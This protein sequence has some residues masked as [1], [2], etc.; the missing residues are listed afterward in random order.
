MNKYFIIEKDNE[1]IENIKN[2]FEESLGYAFAGASDDY[3]ESLNLI[4]KTKPN[5]I[6][7]NVDTAV[8]NLCEFTNELLQFNSYKP[9][10]VAI[11]SS[12]TKAYDAI[13]YNFL[14]YILKPLRELDLRKALLKYEDKN[15]S[16]YNTKVCIKSYKDYQ[17]LNTEDILFLK[18]DNNATDFHMKDGSVISAFKTLKTFEES[19][20]FNF[21]RIHKS[22]IINSE[23]VSRIN[24]GK[25]L[26]TINSNNYSIPFT[27]TYIGNIE[28]INNNLSKSS[29]ISL[30]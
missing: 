7:L 18:A 12:K 2:V 23:Y 16:A 8:T 28:S 13:K 21:L 26:C 4:F 10:L 6:I 20:P 24:Y 27:K 14:D 15:L 25:L 17:Y 5:I 22:Y 1:A 11:S 29:F 19:L 3:E 30:N 9:S